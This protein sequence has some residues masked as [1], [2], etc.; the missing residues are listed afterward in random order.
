MAK[1]KVSIPLDNAITKT[2]HQHLIQAL[3]RLESRRGE[4]GGVGTDYTSGLH[5]DPAVVR[6]IQQ[7]DGSI[8]KIRMILKNSEV[9]DPRLDTTQVEVGN[10]IKIKFEEENEE[11]LYRLGTRIDASYSSDLPWMSV[12]S[13]IGKELRGKKKGDIVTYEVEKQTK[14]VKVI[15]V[16]RES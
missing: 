4:L 3:E 1:E 2:T 11:E 14:K 15:D 10:K 12:E 16:L 6:D 8:D 9:L 7:L 13:P 5:D